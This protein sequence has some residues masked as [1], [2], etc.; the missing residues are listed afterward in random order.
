MS[1]ENNALNKEQFANLIAASRSITKKAA[2]ESI[3]T[4]IEGVLEAIGKDHSVNLS[5]FGK[6]YKIHVKSREG[7]NPKT[8]EKMMIKAYNQPNFSS[9]S[10]LKK[11]ANKTK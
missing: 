6:F 2:L 11:A 1:L 5:G 8:R 9:G 7:V 3:N 4:F 10:D